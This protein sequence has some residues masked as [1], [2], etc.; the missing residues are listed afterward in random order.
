MDI[1]WKYTKKVTE[2]KIKKVESIY[3]ISL[4]DDLRELILFANNGRPSKKVFDTEKTEGHVFKKL[5]SFNEED[6]ENIYTPIDVLRKEDPSLFPFASDPAG[7]FLCLQNGNVVFWLH[8]SGDVE[9]VADSVTTLL[10][11]LY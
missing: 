7:N 4:P 9:Y 6:V 3:G 11:I 2:D 1:T 5:L 10:G 8:E